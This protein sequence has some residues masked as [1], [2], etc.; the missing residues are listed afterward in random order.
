MTTSRFHFLCAVLAGAALVIAIVPSLPIMSNSDDQMRNYIGGYVAAAR[1]H[2]APETEGS[3]NDA[4]SMVSGGDRQ[5][6]LA[7]LAPYT[8]W[9]VHSAVLDALRRLSPHTIE[10]RNWVVF[11]STIVGLLWIAGL[12]WTMRRTFTEHSMAWLLTVLTITVFLHPH[13]HPPDFA[14][15]SLSTFATGIA[16]ALVLAR[17]R[18]DVAIVSLLALGALLHNYQ[19]LLNIAVATTILLLLQPRRV[20]DT[21]LPAVGFIVVSFALTTLAST[22]S[23]QTPWDIYGGG[24]NGDWAS[25]WP[26]NRTAVIQIIRYMSPLVAL[27]VWTLSDVRRGVVAGLAVAASVALPGLL[28]DPGPYLGE[29]PNRLGGAWNCAI[30][31]LLLQRDW[32]TA[33][34]RLIS[35]YRRLAMVFCLFVLA[36]MVVRMDARYAFVHRLQTFEERLG[37]GLDY[38]QGPGETAGLLLIPR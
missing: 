24:I 11:S 23:V 5:R 13:T 25:N 20:L 8:I 30:F 38:P 31:A 35:P 10:L 14:V 32:L 21:M 27:L 12:F 26:K 36:V 2:L 17:K 16:V 34:A 28:T 29:Y 18:P 19:Q 37:N 6:L 33:A 3:V 4:F 22:I 7:A 1:L 15:R 9:I